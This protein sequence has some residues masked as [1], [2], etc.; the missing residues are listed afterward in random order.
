MKKL[1]EA[2]GQ[3]ED[4]IALDPLR[5][6]SY[7]DLGFLES[8]RGNKD[9][10]EQAFKHAVEANPNSIPAKLSLANFYWM[11]SR[12]SE[13]EA[14]LK[15]LDAANPKNVQINRAL[16]AFYIS[17]KQPDQAEQPLKTIVEVNKDDA[18][19]IRLAEYYMAIGKTAEA[20]SLMESVAKGTGE[21][22][23]MAAVRLAALAVAEGRQNDAYKL[24]D[25]S[26]QKNPKNYFAMAAKAEMLLREGKLDEALASAKAGCRSGAS[27]RPLPCRWSSAGFT[28][29]EWSSPMHVAA[30]N[31]AVRLARNSSK[32]ISSWRAHT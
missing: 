5:A 26:L 23:S 6:G 22:A 15:E 2:V 11:S 25:E 24:I 9:A 27:P 28:P 13:S 30:F 3:V 31:E 8:I 18:S 19:R 1:D 17:T 4:A 14:L 29:R 7:L 16:A 32:R 20:R 21:A 12:N 10:A